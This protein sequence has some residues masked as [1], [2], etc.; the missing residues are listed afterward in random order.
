MDKNPKSATAPKVRHISID[1]PDTGFRVVLY[2]NRFGLERLEDQF[3]IHFGLVN[4]AGDVLASYS[5]VFSSDLV[6]SSRTEWLSY[7]GKIGEPPDSAI[8]LTWRPPS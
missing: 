4:K 3:L 1:L 7:L 5:T 8:D 2:F 6:K